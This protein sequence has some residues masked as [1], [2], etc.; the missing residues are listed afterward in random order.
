MISVLVV[1]DH[2]V[3]RTGL[4]HLLATTDDLQCVGGAGDG[5]E[6]LELAERMR[7]DVVLMDLSMPGRD[8]VTVIRDLRRSGSTARILVL[9]SFSDS[10]LVLDAVQAGADGYLLKQCEAEQLLDGIRAVAAGQAPIDPAVAR[11]LLTGVHAHSS[12]PALTARESEVLELVRLGLP[13]KSI[14]R[15]LDISERTVKV[16]MTHIFQRIGVTDRTQAAVWAE[17]HLQPSLQSSPPGDGGR[18]GPVS[19]PGAAGP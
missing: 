15:R 2:A 18:R 3:V 19:G 12:A 13:N 9:T 17:R 8:G 4:A 10:A 1:D 14:A 5:R 7:P 6:A 16:H 11:S